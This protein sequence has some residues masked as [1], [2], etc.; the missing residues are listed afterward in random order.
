MLA[1]VG[2]TY[3]PELSVEFKYVSLGAPP[4]SARRSSTNAT[5]FVTTVR[6]GAHVKLIGKRSRITCLRMYFELELKKA[7]S[8]V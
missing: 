2:P 5:G 7:P 8:K 1:R 3:I 6:L 4:T